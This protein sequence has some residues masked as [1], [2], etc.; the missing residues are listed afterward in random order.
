MGRTGKLGKYCSL[1]YQ[2]LQLNVLRTWC[3]V[4][5]AFCRQ[6]FQKAEMHILSFLPHFFIIIDETEL[7]E[8]EENQTHFSD[9]E[10]G[11]DV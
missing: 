10:Q 5:L 3:L 11:G 4:S 9:G 2:F 6:F 1:M 7:R 8:L